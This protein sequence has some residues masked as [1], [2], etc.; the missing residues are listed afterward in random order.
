MGQKEKNLINEYLIALKKTERMFRANS[1]MAWAGK[2]VRKGKHVIVENARPFH[3]M[4]TGFPDMVGFEQVEI[5]PE[6]VGHKI[7]V[8]KGVEV[9]ATGK[10]SDDQIRFR[11]LILKMGGVFELLE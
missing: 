1:G 7:A 8:F 2:S 4:P 3:G 10:L 11:D 5:T 9:K 6:M